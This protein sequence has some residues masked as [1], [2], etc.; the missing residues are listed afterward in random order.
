M[1]FGI[2]G[3]QGPDQTAHEGPLLS[4][5]AFKVPVITAEDKILVS[6]LISVFRHTCGNL[7]FHF[8]RLGHELLALY[9]Q[10]QL[11]AK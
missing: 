4:A 8:T 1:Y 6:F 7:T 2:H 10:N 3:S 9:R 5:L 11:K